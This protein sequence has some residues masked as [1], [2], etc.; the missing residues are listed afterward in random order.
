MNGTAAAAPPAPPRPR[1]RGRRRPA[2]AG[3]RWGYWLTA[4]A[5]LTG[6][7]AALPS[8]TLFAL[9]MGLL[10]TVAGA[11]ALT[12]SAAS[13]L[14]ISRSLPVREVRE[15]EPLALEFAVRLPRWLPARIE[16][17]TGP[18]AWTPLDGPGGAV[19]LL[20]DRRGAHLVGPSQVRLGD[21]FGIV[22]RR[23]RAGKPEPVLVLPEIGVDT[24]IDPPRGARA[25]DLD[26]DGLRPYVPGSPISRIHWASLA[27]GG[28]LQER[29]MIAPPTGL[30]LVIVDTTGADDPRAIDWVARASAGSVLA[31]A[32]GGGCEVLLPG[33][34]TPLPAVDGPSWRG[35]HRRLALL[36]ADHNGVMAVPPSGRASSIIRVPQ[37]LAFGPPRPDLPPGVAP[38][39]PAQAEDLVAILNG[40]A[41]ER[42]PVA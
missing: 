39:S 37:G 23:V 36:D 6:L 5:I 33:V 28:E 32:R 10:V 19:E 38:L 35:V 9:A 16:V 15:D 4:A 40:Q 29:R 21:P 20:I 26:P 42:A 7:A 13:R 3:S 17:L 1:A 22:R 41:R 11:T 14:S 8:L 31:L 12:L 34:P 27:R 25:D 30:P 18:R 2:R 24:P